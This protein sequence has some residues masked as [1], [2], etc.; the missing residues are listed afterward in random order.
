MRIWLEK[1]YTPE[2]VEYLHSEPTHVIWHY[3]CDLIKQQK[4]KN[5]LDVGCATGALNYFLKDYEY[6]Y[7]GFDASEHLI[8]EA[9]HIWNR[10]NLHFWCADWDNFQF[11]HNCD[12][13]LLL[14]V[15]PYGDSEYCDNDYASPFDLYQ[16]LVKK[17]KPRQV[18]IRETDDVYVDT[19]SEYDGQKIG[20]DLEPFFKIADSVKRITVDT[21]IGKK[22]ILNVIT[23][24]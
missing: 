9:K 20:I 2:Q 21:T 23:G 12:C 1:N 18:I 14:G 5:I 15:L 13:M 10:P 17:F 6:N 11:E 8:K 24:I 4:S 19:N 22:V 16:I 3:I 7:F